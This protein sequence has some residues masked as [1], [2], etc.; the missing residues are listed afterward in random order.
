[1][2]EKEYIMKKEE[3]IERVENLENLVSNMV[4]VLKPLA[5]GNEQLW[6]VVFRD[7]IKAPVPDGVDIRTLVEKL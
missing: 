2:L 7:L 3:L 6:E 5:I 1:V 4:E